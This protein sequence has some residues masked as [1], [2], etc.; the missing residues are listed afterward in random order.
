MVPMPLPQAD[1]GSRGGH[2]RWTLALVVLGG[3]LTVAAIFSIWVNRQALNTDNWVNTGDQLLENEAVR[4]RLSDYLAEQLFEGVDLGAELKAALPPRLAPLAGPAAGG[5][6]QVAPR[7]AERIL[8]SAPFQTVWETANRRAHEALLRILDGETGPI[9]T[10]G[11]KVILELRPA[12]DR[13]A[14]R[15]GIGGAGER[16]PPGAGN[17]TILESSELKTAQDVAKLVRRLPIVLTALL[18]ICFVAAIVLAGPRR[19]EALRAV[20]FAFLAA[21]LLALAVRSFAGSQVVDSLTQVSSAKPATEAVWD[22]AT[23]LLVTVATSAIAFGLILVV[24]AWAAGQTR[25]AVGLRR[26]AQPYALR[27]PGTIYGGAFVVFLA[28][29]AWAPITAFRKPLG[30]LVFALLFAVGTEF[31]RDKVLTEPAPPPPRSHRSH[32]SPG[33]GDAAPHPPS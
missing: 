31:W 5:L 3:V 11:N 13:L 9:A 23:S 7:I 12:V 17:I 33:S 28:L 25:V 10:Q 6:E 22:I 8:A 1:R 14:E 19:R 16:I 18:A 20:G 4:A 29:I 30:V 21:G 15:F 2:P 32:E 24:A 27:G 26:F